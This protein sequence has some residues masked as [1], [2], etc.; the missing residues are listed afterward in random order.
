MFHKHSEGRG[1]WRI[2]NK[3]EWFKASS[4]AFWDAG[5]VG[6]KLPMVAQI[7]RLFPAS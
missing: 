1:Y 4:R 2:L 6:V 5:D 3:H 7:S